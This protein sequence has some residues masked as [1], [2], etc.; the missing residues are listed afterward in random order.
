MARSDPSLAAAALV[1]LRAAAAALDRVGDHARAEATERFAACYPAQGR[2][3]GDDLVA[4]LADGAGP[5]EL[6]E[7]EPWR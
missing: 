3:P 2:S 5:V 1:S 7:A 6:S 4:A